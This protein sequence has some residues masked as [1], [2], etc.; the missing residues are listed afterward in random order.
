MLDKYPRVTVMDAWEDTG[1]HL[2][3]AANPW[4]RIKGLL[5]QKFVP[6]DS[7]LF[8]TPCSSIHCIGMSVTID[9]VYV[10]R[11]NPDGFRKVLGIETVSPGRIGHS[12]RH[13]NSVL[14]LSEG[15]AERHDIR[16]GDQL[17]LVRDGGGY[18]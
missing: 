14:E 1:L 7:G 11:R 8:I 3:V 12:P 10:S 15:A 2:A 9:V 6:E 17:A 16:V 18:R 5:G 4:R 13:A